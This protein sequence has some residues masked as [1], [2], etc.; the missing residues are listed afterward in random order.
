MCRVGTRAVTERSPSARGSCQKLLDGLRDLCGGD[1]HQTT[2]VR[3]VSE[4][5]E[6]AIW[7]AVED[8]HRTRTSRLPS[9]DI[10]RGAENDDRGH[11]VQTG[12]VAEERVVGHEDVAIHE[13]LVD[14]LWG[15]APTLILVDAGDFE[16]AITL[17]AEGPYDNLRPR[18]MEPQAERGKILGRPLFALTS[19]S[20]SD[21]DPGRSVR[22]HRSSRVFFQTESRLEKTEG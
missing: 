16:T 4:S 5:A 19:S 12:E 9:L 3:A 20:G 17:V 22:P 6:C 13:Y 11:A 14:L 10:V 21:A 15:A 8:G 7:R 1:G 2:P 18:F